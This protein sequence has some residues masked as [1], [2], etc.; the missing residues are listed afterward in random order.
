MEEMLEQV[1]FQYLVHVLS[2]FVFCLV[3][4]FVLFCVLSFLC[5]LLFAANAMLVDCCKLSLKRLSQVSKNGEEAGLQF[6]LSKDAGRYLCD[7]VY[8]R[9]ET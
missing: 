3:L 1:R 9:F 2:C 7:F 6:Q 4:Y 5:F 8:Y